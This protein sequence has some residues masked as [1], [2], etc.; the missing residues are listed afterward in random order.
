LPVNGIMA[1]MGWSQSFD[2]SIP[3]PRGDLLFTLKVAVTYV[4]N[5]RLVIEALIMAA[6][7][8]GPLMH[9]RIG[10][11]R[12]L[13]RHVESEF[14]PDRK[15]HHWGSAETGEGSVT[16]HALRRSDQSFHQEGA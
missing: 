4:R 7:D 16:G 12:N 6:E 13:D 10:V 1:E 3:P 9:A 5:G 8:R 14:N 11:M 15:D 2:D